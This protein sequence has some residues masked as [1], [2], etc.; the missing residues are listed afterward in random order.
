MASS[1]GLDINEAIFGAACLFAVVH[2]YFMY[3][4]YPKMV[5]D[6]GV[7]YPDIDYN[8][9][10]NTNS[11]NES[12]ALGTREVRAWTY[13]SQINL[14]WYGLELLVWGLNLAFDNEAGRIHYLLNSLRSL[15]W[16]VMGL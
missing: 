7:K 11:Q 14:V 3:D 12:W 10:T 4:W 6:D 2:G 13:A 8:P 1:L 16:L 5:K 15:S 9:N